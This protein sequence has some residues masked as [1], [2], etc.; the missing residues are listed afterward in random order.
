VPAFVLFLTMVLGTIVM[1][2][3]YSLLDWNRF[4]KPIFFGLNNFINLFAYDSA[5]S[6]IFYKSVR[7]ALMLA[8]LSVFVQ[9]PI[10][11]FFALILARGIRGENFFRTV[12]FI[13]VVIS[14]V[15]IGQ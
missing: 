8:F 9:L 15:I 14:A 6:V 13:P 1:S 11:L 7:N 2:A 4:Q 3:Y 10:A 5:D 12:Y